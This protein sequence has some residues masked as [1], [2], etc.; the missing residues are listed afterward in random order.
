M[1]NLS[2]QIKGLM[3]K[4][5]GSEPPKG[6]KKSSY[7]TSSLE[8]LKDDKESIY[9]PIG[10]KPQ[11]APFASNGAFLKQSKAEKGNLLSV[12]ECP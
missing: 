8:P 10:M 7:A 2:L 1:K 11:M 9:F 4:T 5:N 3:A 12:R 6:A